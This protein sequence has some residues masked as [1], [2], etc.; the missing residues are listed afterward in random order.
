MEGVCGEFRG[1]YKIVFGDMNRI[2]GRYN[3]R[4]EGSYN[5]D[6]FKETLW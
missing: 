1:T 5:R 2:N 3:A 6:E 4:W